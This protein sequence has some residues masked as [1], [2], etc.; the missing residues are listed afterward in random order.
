MPKTTNA[1]AAASDAPARRAAPVS[2]PLKPSAELA[3]IVGHQSLS[4]IEI[5]STL[6]AYIREHNLQHPADAR[7][8]I[9]VDDKLRA[10]FGKERCTIFEIGR[11]LAGCHDRLEGR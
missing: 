11:D 8:R 5:V 9:L 1:K 6:W 2:K 10:V 4:R 3:A 7:I